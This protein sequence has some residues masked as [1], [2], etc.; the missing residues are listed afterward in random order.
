MF[1]SGGGRVDFPSFQG[2]ALQSTTVGLS[3]MPGCML[4]DT[5]S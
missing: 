4:L 1:V 2:N 5:F 3:I